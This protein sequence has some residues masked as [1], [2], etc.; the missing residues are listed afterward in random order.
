MFQSTPPRGGRLA[1]QVKYTFLPSG[2][3]SIHAPAR[4]ATRN[5][6]PRGCWAGYYAGF[7]PRPR[8]GG[9]ITRF[10][11]ISCRDHQDV[12]I[13]AP[14]R[15]ATHLV[16]GSQRSPRLSFNPRPRAGGD[17]V[18]RYK[19]DVPTLMFQST[20]PR[21]G[22]LA[23][24]LGG[25][26]TGCPSFNPRPRAGGDWLQDLSLVTD[27]PESVS[28]HAPA[29]GATM[30]LSVG[31]HFCGHKFQSTPPRGG[32]LRAPSAGNVRRVVPCFN[33]RPRAGG[34]VACS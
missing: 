31:P 6:E 22:R 23:A 18:L 14:A 1:D 17:I 34:D 20:P 24:A 9:D 13:H 21:G 33:P 28:I 2:R 29:R 32:R 4:G 3:V 5:P 25:R 27:S 16:M 30:K 7:N 15:G 12:S 26:A 19:K 11:P 8:A 10:E